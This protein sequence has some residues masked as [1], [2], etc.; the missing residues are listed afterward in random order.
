[1]EKL[2]SI[3]LLLEAFGNCRTSLNVN[4][5]RFTQIF[6]LDFDQTGQIASASIQVSIRTCTTL[7]GSLIALGC[8][9]QVEVWK[10]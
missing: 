7:S 6:S 4:A 2:N 1:V 10:P 8:W 9:C 3:F 5:T